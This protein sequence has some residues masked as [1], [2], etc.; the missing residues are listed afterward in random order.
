MDFLK[1]INI[2][3]WWL[4]FSNS[5]WV[6]YCELFGQEITNNIYNILIGHFPDLVNQS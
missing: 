3:F 5:F 2:S 4:Y 6:S 1:I